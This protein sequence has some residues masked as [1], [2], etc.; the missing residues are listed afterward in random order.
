MY[1]VYAN[2]FDI[3]ASILLVQSVCLSVL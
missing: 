1:E 2:H 3:V